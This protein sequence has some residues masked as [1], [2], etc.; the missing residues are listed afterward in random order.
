MYT[1]A[2]RLTATTTERKLQRQK[3]CKN[4]LVAVFSKIKLI[5]IYFGQKNNAHKRTLFLVVLTTS[6]LPDGQAVPCA[7]R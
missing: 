7:N 2:R 3:S 5:E 6:I 4:V 1:T